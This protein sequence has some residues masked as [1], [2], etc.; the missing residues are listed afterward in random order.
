[1]ILLAI[2]NDKLSKIGMSNNFLNQSLNLLFRYKLQF[3]NKINLTIM[4]NIF[5]IAQ[6]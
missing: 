1:M 6:F 5:Q 4:K 3:E 2:I